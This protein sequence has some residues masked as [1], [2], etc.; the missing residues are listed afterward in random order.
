[1]GGACITGTGVSE[2]GG[3]PDFDFSKHERHTGTSSRSF[4]PASVLINYYCDLRTT[5]M[6]NPITLETFV[7]RIKS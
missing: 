1:M 6:N 3:F 7:C 5:N 4:G 2:T